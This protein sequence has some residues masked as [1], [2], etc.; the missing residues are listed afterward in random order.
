MEGGSKMIAALVWLLNTVLILFM[1]A[2]LAQMALSWLIAFKRITP[3]N[4]VVTPIYSGLTALTNPLLRPAR[5]I[6]PPMG[7][8]DFSPILVIVLL[9]FLRRLFDSLLSTSAVVGG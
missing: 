1:L 3:Q 6:L 2:I 5:A 7:G 4:T 8:L 9:E